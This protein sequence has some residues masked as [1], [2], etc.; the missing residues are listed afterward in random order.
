MS[1]V[2]R[3]LPIDALTLTVDACLAAIGDAGLTRSDIDGLATWPGP[4]F[5][6]PGLTG[7][8]TLDVQEALRLELAWSQA[9]PEGGQLAPFVSACLAVAAGLAEHVLVYRT[10]TEA[11]AQGAGGRGVTALAGAAGDAVEGWRKWLSPFHAYAAPTFVALYAQRH[12]WA[13]GTTREQLGAIALNARRNAAANPVAVYRTP[14]TMDEYLAGRP[15]STP[16]TLYDCDVPVDG[17]VAFIITRSGRAV[18]G[19]R[20]PLQV[21]AIGTAIRHRPSFE[22]WDD[23]TTMAAHDV[24]RHLWSRT[25]LTPADVDVA[26]LYDGFTMLPIMWLE[27]LG[28]CAPG[29]GGPFVEGGKRIDRV[30]GELPLNTGG[31]QLSAGRLHGYGVLHE[32]CVQLWGLGADRQAARPEVAVVGIGGGPTAGAVLLT[33]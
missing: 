1:A 5:G 4:E 22:Q 2:G 18:T 28:F 26:E 29:E 19:E 23:M 30:G 9:G 20:P 10:V 6:T 31:G 27:A 14:L 13:Y 11:S 16:F 24:S 12:M 32:A 3:R 8:G 7:P 33:T 21:D 25:N 15:I 17:S